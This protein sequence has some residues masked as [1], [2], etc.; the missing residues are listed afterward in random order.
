MAAAEP[1]P[2]RLITNDHAARLVLPGLRGREAEWR[3]RVGDEA[4]QASI[5]QWENLLGD[6]TPYPHAVYPDDNPKSMS[7]SLREDE[8]W[9]RQ[10]LGDWY[11]QVLAY[12]K[13]LDTP[14]D[15]RA[16]DATAR[17]DSARGE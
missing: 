12:R 7:T 2:H 5:A 1:H 6:H 15:G 11:D 17:T 8:A 3:E 13:A 9:W 4:Y 10:A 14:D 16:T